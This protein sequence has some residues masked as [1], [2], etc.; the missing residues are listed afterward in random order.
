MAYDHSLEAIDLWT[1]IATAVLGVIDHSWPANQLMTAY[2]WQIPIWTLAAVILRR[3]LLAPYWMAQ[4]DAAAIADATERRKAVERQQ[5]AHTGRGVMFGFGTQ[6]FTEL[7][8]GGP[9]QVSGC[10]IEGLKYDE[11]VAA[12]RRRIRSTRTWRKAKEPLARISHQRHDRHVL[13][14]GG[15]LAFAQ[16]LS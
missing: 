14:C 6:Y 7:E 9:I 5:K 1:G 12:W 10:S 2:A 3:L 4:E 13:F 11:G 16:A 8:V 15:P